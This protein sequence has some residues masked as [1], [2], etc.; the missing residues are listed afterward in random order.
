VES[1]QQMLSSTEATA[2][3]ETARVSMTISG[4]TVETFAQVVG[5]MLSNLGSMFGG[6]PQPPPLLSPGSTSPSGGS[7]GTT[8]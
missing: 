4:K 5:P 8:P 1:Q 7:Q 2:S 6:T 3:G